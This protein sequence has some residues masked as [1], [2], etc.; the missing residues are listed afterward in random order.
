MTDRIDCFNLSSTYL[1]LEDG[2]RSIPVAVSD[3][4]F[5]DLERDFGDFKG[6]RLV[7]YFTFNEDWETWEMHPAGEEFVCL[8]SGRVDLIL[9]QDGIENTVHLSQSG[10]YVLIPR[11]TWHTAK[12][13]SPSSML[14][15]TPGEGTQNRQCD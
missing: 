13:L 2:G 11:G 15:I 14:F 4:F 9:E 12:V 5:A 10:S 7:S 8:L 6:R 3:R 1:V